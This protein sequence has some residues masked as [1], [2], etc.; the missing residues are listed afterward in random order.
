[1]QRGGS[2]VMHAGVPACD[3]WGVCLQLWQ[4]L[5]AP[6]LSLSHQGAP[7]PPP[8]PSCPHAF[9]QE[10]PTPCT[11]PPFPQPAAKLNSPAAPCGAAPWP[12]PDPGPAARGG[13]CTRLV[14]A[15]QPPPWWVGGGGQRAAGQPLQVCM[16]MSVCTRACTHATWCTGHTRT[17]KH[18]PSPH[19]QPGTAAEGTHPLSPP[20]H[21]VQIDGKWAAQG[22]VLGCQ[23]VQ[24]QDRAICG[25]HGT[26][27]AAR[28]HV[29]ALLSQGGAKDGRRMHMRAAPHELPMCSKALREQ[30]CPHTSSSGAVRASGWW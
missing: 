16:C 6:A 18:S 17:L 3:C 20:A 10:K 15:Q 13:W 29:C 2:A 30:L 7:P 9:M 11:T 26:E 23:H 27:H 5:H 21:V 25:E 8:N 1:M 4:G 22:R 12:D 28:I 14:G 19:S 24:G